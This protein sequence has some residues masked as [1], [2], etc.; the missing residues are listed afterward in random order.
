MSQTISVGVVGPS[1]WT[2]MATVMAECLQK[3]TQF[4]RIEPGQIPGG[5]FRDAV[6]F[7]R[8]ALDATGNSTPDNPPASLNAYGIAAEVIRMSADDLVKSRKEVD[9]RL[10]AYA[11]FI[12]KLGEPR[13]LRERERETAHHLRTFFLNLKEQGEAEAYESSVAFGTVPVGLRHSA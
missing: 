1:Y 2:Y 12:R 10:A 11:D 5:V 9:Q 3:I 6:A 4:N 7:S 13:A 8:L